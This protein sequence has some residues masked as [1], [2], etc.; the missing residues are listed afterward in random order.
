MKICSKFLSS[1]YRVLFSC[2][3]TQKNSIAASDDDDENVL[4]NAL[5]SASESGDINTIRKLLDMGVNASL[6]RK[7]RT[8]L[9]VACLQ[10]HFE[11]VALLVKQQNV[12]TNHGNIY[13]KHTPLTAA[14]NCGSTQCLRILLENSANPTLWNSYRDTPLIVSCRLGYVSCVTLLL[15]QPVVRVDRGA[16]NTAA[17][18][19]NVKCLQA[20][21]ENL[22]DSSLLNYD[23]KDTMNSSTALMLAADRGHLACVLLLL[24]QHGIDVN[25]IDVSGRTTVVTASKKSCRS[26]CKGYSSLLLAAKNNHVEVVRALLNK[27]ANAELRSTDGQTALSLA[28]SNECL[29]CIQ[30]LQNK[31]GESV[32]ELS[33]LSLASSTVTTSTQINYISKPL[34]WSVRKVGYTHQSSSYLADVVGKCYDT[35]KLSGSDKENRLPLI[36]SMP[37][38]TSVPIISRKFGSTYVNNCSNLQLNPCH[39]QRCELDDSAN[40][41]L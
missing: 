12:D 20:L 22:E 38:S 3:L 6:T 24:E 5:I 27:G 1:A 29:A 18:Y 28:R 4:V 31:L 2:V 10:G 19:G 25:Q 33:E 23:V 39:Y 9:T 16:L 8:A 26:E 15:E 13:Y 17:R 35:R 30:L 40:T 7:S 11:I 14:A 34:D 21:L 32:D 37:G 41:M 36:S